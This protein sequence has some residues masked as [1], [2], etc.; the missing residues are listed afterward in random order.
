MTAFV[1]PGKHQHSDINYLRHSNSAGYS[2]FVAAK[3]ATGRRN[4]SNLTAT[5]H[6]PGVFFYV[7]ALAS[8][9]L[10]VWLFMAFTCHERYIFKIMVVLAG[11]SSGWPVF[12]RAGIPTPV[13]AT[14]YERRNSGGGVNRYLTEV[15]IMAATPVL[16][17]SKFTFLFLAV[18]RA[19]R[20]ARPCALR[21]TAGSEHEARLHL[22]SNF[23]LCFAGRLPVHDCGEVTA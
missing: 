15:A 22:T 12:V 5:Q 11:Q 20:S 7:A 10:K 17:H 14:T 8:L 23:I 21:I 3:S 19:D 1:Q 18:L 13:W 4:P 6:A 9:F 2:F 16:S